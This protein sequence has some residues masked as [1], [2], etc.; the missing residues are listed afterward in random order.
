MKEKFAFISIPMRDRSE[1]EIN[2]DFDRI[3]NDYLNEYS[4]LYTLFSN[5]LYKGESPITY[6]AM[7]IDKMAFAD[8]CF[9]AKGWQDAR[10]CRVEHLVAQEYGIPCIYEDD[11]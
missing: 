1:E 2:A 11:Q 5:P 8:V 4:I 7:S 6:L 10:G 9:F 3:A